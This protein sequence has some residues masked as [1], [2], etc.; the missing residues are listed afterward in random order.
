MMS[1][2]TESVNRIPLSYA[3]FTSARLSHENLAHS[4]LDLAGIDADGLDR[5]KSIFAEAFAESPRR[6]VVRGTLHEFPEPGAAAVPLPA[7]R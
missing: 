3:L 2:K 5:S 6:Y 7:S 1:A 4:V